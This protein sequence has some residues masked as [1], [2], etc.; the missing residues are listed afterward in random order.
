MRFTL[1]AVACLVLAACAAATPDDREGGGDRALP[2]PS[3][4]I[5]GGGLADIE[6]CDAEEYRPLIGTDVGATAFP[7]SAEL[8][9]FGVDD[10]VTQ[11]YIP[12][13]TNIVFDR[14]RR[15]VRVYCG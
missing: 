1:P 10:I 6:L 14:S 7:V 2:G 4:E 8:R 3:E 9:V 13:R 15:I 12:Q 11:D 5:D